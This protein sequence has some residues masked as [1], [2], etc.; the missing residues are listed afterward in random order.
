[1]TKT[2]IKIV[3]E[4]L[5]ANG[6]SGLVQADADCGCEV[7]DLQPCG[8]DFASCKAGYKHCDPRPGRDSVWLISTKQEPPS[9]EAFD[10]LEPM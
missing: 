8:S 10:E 6:F 5:R 3:E 1:M 4:H 2:V 9:L 7:D